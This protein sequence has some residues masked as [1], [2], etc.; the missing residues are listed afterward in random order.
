MR[1][2]IAWLVLVAGPLLADE[3]DVLRV[4][5]RET[6]TGGQADTSLPQIRSR[7]TSIESTA[8]GYLQSMDKSA[9]RRTLWTD[10]A[11][12]TNSSHITSNWRRLRD[13]A[14]AWATPGQT[15]HQNAEMLSAVRGGMDWM[16]ANRYNARVTNKYDNWWDW[17]IGSAI[18]AGNLLTL[19]YEELSEAEVARHAAAIDRF[20]ADPRIMITSTVST[21]A[22]RVWKCKGAILR[23][24]AVRDA[25]KLKL[26]SDALSPVFPYVTGGD[27]FYEDGSFIQHARHP[28]TGGYGNALM[29]DLADVLYLLSGSPWEVTDRARDNVWRWV[30]ESFEP[31]IYR[32]AMM[33]MVVIVGT[34]AAQPTPRGRGVG[35]WRRRFLIKIRSGRRSGWSSGQ[36]TSGSPTV[37]RCSKRRWPA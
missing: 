9:G 25:A 26:A 24:I 33:D 35:V 23:A 20:V 6:L 22:N 11:S 12:T 31:A 14:L 15:Y 1:T 10:L 37:M 29:N 5:W 30:V 34:R 16:E 28:Y 13:M 19:V 27:G 32:G 2:A 18:E 7:L 4:R 8:R 17:E 36:A 3:F 21:G